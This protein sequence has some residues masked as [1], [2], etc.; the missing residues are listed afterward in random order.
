MRSLEGLR[1]GFKVGKWYIIEVVSGSFKDYWLFKFHSQDDDYIYQDN[2]SH[3]F[4]IDEVTGE[5][6][7]FQSY[8]SPDGIS[9][10]LCGIDEVK[11]IRMVSDEQVKEYI[12]KGY[13]I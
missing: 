3:T 9:H 7:E 11:N 13:E 4:D 5:F 1:K 12:K 6:G 2:I 10:P 8:P